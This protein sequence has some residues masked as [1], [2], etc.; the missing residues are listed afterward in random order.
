[1]IYSFVQIYQITD[2]LKKAVRNG[3]YL[4][5]NGYILVFNICDNEWCFNGKRKNFTEGHRVQL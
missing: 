1:M 5:M 4:L 2:H 3:E